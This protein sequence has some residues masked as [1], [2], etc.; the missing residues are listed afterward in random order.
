MRSFCVINHCR[1]SNYYSIINTQ[2]D[3]VIPEGPTPRSER[4]GKRLHQPIMANYIQPS[5]RHRECLGFLLRTG[6]C[7]CTRVPHGCR[8][9][10]LCPKKGISDL[11]SPGSGM[12][13]ARGGRQRHSV[14]RSLC[15]R[16]AALLRDSRRLFPQ[17]SCLSPADGRLSPPHPSTCAHQQVV[18]PSIND[19]LAL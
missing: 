19:T 12:A 7:S 15:L 2:T 10:K 11:P 8:D 6:Q 9:F 3:I 4:G 5:H 13:R 16:R 18:R 17:L 1:S 14:I